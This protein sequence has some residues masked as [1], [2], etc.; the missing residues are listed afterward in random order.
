MNTQ[1]IFNYLMR[2][3]FAVILLTGTMSCDDE[4]DLNPNNAYSSGN[5]WTSETNAML[6]LTGV[7]RGGVNY[8]LSPHPTDWWTVPGTIL[9]ELM[10]DNGYD[11]R[12]DNSP[13]NTITNGQLTANND[14]IRRFWVNSYK[15]IAICNNFIENI[16]RA[17]FGETKIKRMEAE[18]RFVRASQ[19]FYMSQ[20][21]GSVPLVTKTLSDQEANTVVKSPTQEIVQFV[22]DELIEV[23]G[24]L[25]LHRELT[26]DDKGRV[27]K[28][29]ALAFLGRMYLSDHRYNEAATVYKEI[30]DYGDNAIDPDFTSLF[31]GTNENSSEI[32]FAYQY[33][34]NV[35]QNEFPQRA[36][37]R[38][39]GGYN[40]V[41]PYSDLADQYDWNDG[42][43]F[44]YEDERY[45][46]ENMAANRDPRFD[47]TFY[48]DNGTFCNTPISFDPDDLQS[49]DRITYTLQATRSGY[50]LRKFFDESFTGPLNT[51]YGADMPIIRYAEIL[52]SYLEAKLESGSVITQ[53]LLD[54]TINTV[55]S[56]TSVDMP[57]IIETDPTKLRQILRKERR[58]EFAFEG[59][60][61]WDLLRWGI[62][63]EV[64]QGDFWGAP[65]PNSARY[66]TT[67]KK[68]DPAG[69]S[70]WFVTS[71][72]FRKGQDETWPI[73]ESESNINPG[74]L[75]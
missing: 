19:Y 22:I 5:F 10:S 49:L 18:A 75:N 59:F 68:I 73:P 35:Y 41:N 71:K 53:D 34:A 31:N 28:Q 29:A 61:Y 1:N 70:R 66:A 8:L 32:L 51:G 2:G 20:Y 12:G 11:R 14:Y 13:F 48:C 7:Y 3:I 69:Y 45:N 38:S 4:L 74:L 21:W 17:E 42:T 26:S 50:G 57:P 30:M 40:F 46:P 56:R 25:P 65:F 27:S 63:G 37:P 54:E 67:T 64:L 33:I 15:R 24:A 52:L 9:F 39:L 55:R 60:R 43:S 23:S 44:S 58:I 16:G 72:A 6:A 62:T 47:Y 36:Y